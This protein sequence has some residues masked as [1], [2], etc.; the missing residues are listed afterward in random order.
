MKRITA[1]AIVLIQG[2]PRYGADW[3]ADKVRF[4]DDRMANHTL[5]SA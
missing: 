5:F 2:I 1:F 4:H 3:Q